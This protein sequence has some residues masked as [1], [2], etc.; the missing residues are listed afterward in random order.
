MHWKV[1]NS[2]CRHN[3]VV[4]GKLNVQ[5]I[6]KGTITK[7][8]KRKL[9]ALSHYQFKTR[10]KYKAASLG[11]TLRTQNEWGTT[12]G[13]PCCGRANKLTLADRTFVCSGCDYKALRDD[14]AACCI[15]LKHL[16]GVW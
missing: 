12:S 2:I 14:K 3:L 5:S 7:S 6:L 8:A 16:A 4:I 9:Q 1:I 11:V 10:L 13:C 15:M